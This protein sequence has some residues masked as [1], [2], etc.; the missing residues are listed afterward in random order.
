VKV[1][2]L[3]AAV[4]F[5]FFI[6]STVKAIDIPI[7]SCPFNITQSNARYYLTNDLTF[8]ASH[9]QRVMTWPDASICI[10]A[11]L[12]SNTVLDLNGYTIFDNLMTGE[13]GG[14]GGWQIDENYIIKL[15]STDHFTITNG[16]LTS[17]TDK[18]ICRG[19]MDYSG[20][21]YVTIDRVNMNQTSCDY[22]MNVQGLGSHWQITNSWLYA[23][24]ANL[25]SDFPYSFYGN[26]SMLAPFSHYVNAHEFYSLG[27]YNCYYGMIFFHS[28]SDNNYFE[29]LVLDGVLNQGGAN[30]TVVNS[31]CYLPLLA[32]TTT[33]TTTTSTTTTT[34]TT[35]PTTTTTISPIPLPISSCMD[36]T[37]G[38]YYLT[39]NITASTGGRCLGIYGNY[40]NVN[41]N[42]YTVKI[43]STEVFRTAIEVSGNN[44]QLYNGYTDYTYCTGSGLRLNFVTNSTFRN[45]IMLLS[46]GGCGGFQ[47]E[48]YSTWGVILQNITLIGDGGGYPIH[49]ADIYCTVAENI[50]ELNYPAGRY[51]FFGGSS[52][53]S[54]SKGE[55]GWL[56]V[57]DSYTSN[58]YF[59]GNFHEIW[60]FGTNNTL[61]NRTDY[62]N[63]PSPPNPCGILLPPPPIPAPV[64][65]PCDWTQLGS[66]QVV[67]RFECLLINT[68]VCNPMLVWLIVLFLLV[69]GSILYIRT[70]R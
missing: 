41:L 42:G 9:W 28:P 17:N 6:A 50:K 29:G 70:R 5:F 68:I 16:N 49:A 11:T 69:I 43:T 21:V 4:F 15:N 63:C 34:T 58:N 35:I 67:L 7:S 12:V 46:G 44:I 38:N 8:D 40:I 32:P 54:F 48:M 13:G 51:S 27:M 62:W 2:I 20:S 22:G 47:L 64:C 56:F 1:K 26:L 52:N 3:I 10:F 33:T 60:D 18:L 53:N 66:S 61:V 19:I 24:D 25:D 37:A 30:N 65:R 36:I 55:Y 59:C 57:L 23:N 31:T 39:Q 45:I 14:A